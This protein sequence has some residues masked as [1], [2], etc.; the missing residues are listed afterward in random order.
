MLGLHGLQAHPWEFE[1]R[2]LFDQLRGEYEEEER[3]RA[4]KRSKK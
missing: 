3:K 1:V 2:N 4:E